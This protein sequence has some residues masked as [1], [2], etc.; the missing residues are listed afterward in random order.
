[1]LLLL[2]MIPAQLVVQYWSAISQQAEGPLCAFQDMFHTC[3]RRVGSAN[4]I[5]L[6]LNSLSLI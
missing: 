1:V 6:G 2:A 5:A 4:R 3:F